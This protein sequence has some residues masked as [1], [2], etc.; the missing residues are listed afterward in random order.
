MKKNIKLYR[1]VSGEDIIALTTISETFI[2]LESPL[3]ISSS[4]KSN[5]QSVI[6]SLWSPVNV[7][8][9]NLCALNPNNILA[10]FDPAEVVKKYYLETIARLKKAEE[11][12]NNLDKIKEDLTEEDMNELLAAM[13]EG[14]GSVKH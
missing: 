11:A 6:L 8:D 5:K 9:T 1:L 3:E 10:I 7:I 4:N 12:A 2:Y 14:I 13:E